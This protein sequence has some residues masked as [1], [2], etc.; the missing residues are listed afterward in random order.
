MLGSIA[1][2]LFLISLWSEQIAATVL[3]PCI[4]VVV[5]IVVAMMVAETRSPAPDTQEDTQEQGQAPTAESPSAID[6][7]AG[8]PFIPLPPPETIKR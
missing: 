8:R 1:S 6:E 2:L 3:F 4:G 5:V 7:P